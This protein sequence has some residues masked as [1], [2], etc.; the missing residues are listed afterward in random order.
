[1]NAAC[2]SAAP[3]AECDTHSVIFGDDG[4]TL[5]SVTFSVKVPDV[6]TSTTL[7]A[8]F[9]ALVT[10][11]EGNTLVSGSVVLANTVEFDLCKRQKRNACHLKA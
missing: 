1:M 11:A 2:S 4:D 8:I 3:T 9:S 6:T 10:S 7:E 5:T